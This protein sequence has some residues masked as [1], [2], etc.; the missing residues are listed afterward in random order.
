MVILK[1]RVWRIR[2]MA[3]TIIKRFVSFVYS[4]NKGFFYSTKLS[5]ELYLAEK[6]N[7]KMFEENIYSQVLTVWGI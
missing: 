7:Q 1:L 3:Y 2:R 5:S 6:V 4:A